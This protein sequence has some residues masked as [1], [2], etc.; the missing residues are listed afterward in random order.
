MPTEKWERVPSGPLD[1]PTN[2]EN[3][4]RLTMF[5]A[6]APQIS[7][8]TLNPQGIAGSRPLSQ[9]IED[10]FPNIYRTLSTSQPR[11]HPAIRDSWTAP[12][13]AANAELENVDGENVD[14]PPIDGGRRAWLFMVGA[15]MVEGLM[16]GKYLTSEGQ[17]MLRFHRVPFNL[18]SFPKLL[19]T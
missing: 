11:R 6:G 7:M 2:L 5:D 18:W 10:A 12:H 15:F 16:W 19:R 17:F 14:L 4:N 1:I 3:G 8:R 13:P 9:S